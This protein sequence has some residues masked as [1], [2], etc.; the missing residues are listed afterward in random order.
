MLRAARNVDG[1]RTRQSSNQPA[2]RSASV[3][4]RA[5]VGIVEHCVAK[6]AHAAIR[7]SLRLGENIYQAVRHLCIGEIKADAVERGE[8]SAKIDRIAH[9][10][11]GNNERASRVR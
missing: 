5:D 1:A 11:V 7:R 3:T 2:N 6:A 4:R 8:H 9:H 10:G